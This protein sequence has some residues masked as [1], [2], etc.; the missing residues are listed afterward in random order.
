M[1]FDIDA[2][3]YRSLFLYVG[4]RIARIQIFEWIAFALVGFG[5][6]LFTGAA[7]WMVSKPERN[8]P[9]IEK[10]QLDPSPIQP[11]HQ[12]DVPDNQ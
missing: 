3:H 2:F 10:Q 4:S 7:I 11:H 9:H 5:L 12:R 8:K 1:P 6:L